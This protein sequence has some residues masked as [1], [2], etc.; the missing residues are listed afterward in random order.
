MLLV[1]V[2]ILVAV[3]ILAV[4]GISAAGAAAV[5]RILAAAEGTSAGR[6]YRGPRRAPVS[7]RS[8]LLPFAGARTELPAAAL[9]CGPIETLLW[10]RIPRARIE[11]PPSIAPRA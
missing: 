1:V 3:V 5:A 6:Q 7:T 9:H 11:A 4:A 2:A 8:A 10:A